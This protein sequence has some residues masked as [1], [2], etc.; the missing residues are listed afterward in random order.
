MKVLI[1]DDHK[2]FREGLKQIL[3]SDPDIAVV[4]EAGNGQ[5]VLNLVFKKKFDV[6]ILDISMPGRNGLEIL[7][8]LK[9]EKPEIQVL[10]LSMY[11]EEQFAVQAIKAGAS[12]YLTKNGAAREVVAAIRK[13][14]S[15]GMYISA[16]VALEL[17]SELKGDREKTPHSKLS[18]R[19]YQ[20]MCLIA[21]G[22]SNAEIA[23][24]L[25]VSPSAVS[26]H[27]NR[28]LTKMNLKTNADIIRYAIKQG[29][30][31]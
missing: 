1:A 19:E 31:E 21:S 8:E 22:K 7:Q 4:E 15:G 14:V 12:G 9:V 5:E 11:N 23:N 26:T 27:R 13:I 28:I 6:I 3:L 29:L 30:V 24:E 16:A 25:S 18:P 20:V 2:M 10:M 17:A